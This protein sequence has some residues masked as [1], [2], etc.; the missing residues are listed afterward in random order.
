[1]SASLA[2]RQ[3][4]YR[5]R[6][7]RVRR[8]LAVAEVGDA[9]LI[10]GGPSRQ[11][12]IGAAACTL[13]PRLLSCLDGRHTQ[14][15]VCSDLALGDAQFAQAMRLL[16]G[17]GL[18]EWVPPNSAPGFAADHVSVYMSRT[19]GI[20]ESC[21][22]SDDLGHEL[23]VATVVVVA[24]SALADA[25][26]ADLLESGVGTVRTGTT[27]QAVEAL[28]GTQGPCAGVVFDDPVV[29]RDLDEVVAPLREHDV[30]V[31]RCSGTL[32]VAEVGPV[33][34]GVDTACINCFRRRPRGATLDGATGSPGLDAAVTAVLAGLVTSAVLSILTRQGPSPLRRLTTTSL[35]GPATESCEVVPDLDCPVCMRGTP[36]PDEASQ[37]VLA[38]E[39]QVRRLPPALEP[40]DAPTPAAQRMLESF[41]RQRDEFPAFPRHR[42]ADQLTLA[43]SETV[44]TGRADEVA[45]TGILVRTAGF[46]SA[47]D[48][49][50]RWMKNSRWAPSGGNLGSVAIYVITEL[51]PF[52]L[53]GTI[54]RYLDTRHSV[55]SV[56]SERTDLADVLAETDLD[57]SRTLA[58][59]VLV[60]EVGRLRQ[61]YDDFAWRLTHLDSGCAA[62]QLRLVAA[63]Y[64]LTATFASTWSDQIGERLELEQ[65]HEL[66]TA[67]AGLS[68][69]PSGS[70]R[71]L[72]CE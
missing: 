59:L 55:I 19:L 3:S 11:M 44:C 52:G 62:L 30:P 43:A 47:P 13:L 61:K 5:G 56:R 34:L 72:I 16:D 57:L 28:A 50:V 15:E 31:L 36:P 12:L 70:E 8:G 63:S 2:P 33:F 46:R 60:G 40:V 38:Y 23:A 29:P 21:L 24:P 48:S 10:E 17:S 64:G 66:V 71:L 35:D 69:G 68:S 49:A 42:L 65:R 39:W 6:L 53:P 45:L 7:P 27:G 58:A 54:F 20:T 32:G 1:M 14:A 26:M 9:L 4:R 51:D 25:V 67:I 22:C 37:R 41:Q 18:L